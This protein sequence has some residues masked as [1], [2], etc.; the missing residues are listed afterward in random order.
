MWLPYFLDKRINKKNLVGVLASLLDAGG[1][2]GSVA[3][4]WIGDKMGYRSPIVALFLLM[5]LPLIFLFQ[6]G[7]EEIYWLY[8]IVIPATGFFI[9]GP[10]NIISTA[11]AADLAQNPDIENKEEAMATVTGIVDGTGGIGAAIGVLIMGLL[12]DINWL[13]VFL[14]MVGTGVL[15]IACIFHIALREFREMRK[16]RQITLAS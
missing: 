1:V 6:V 10:S 8:F 4:G 15:S 9:A 3:C 7:T 14:F 11:I 5:S 12:A 2:I 16:K 13:Y